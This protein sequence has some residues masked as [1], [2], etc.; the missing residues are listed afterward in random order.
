MYYFIRT[1]ADAW[2]TMCREHCLLPQ[3]IDHILELSSTAGDCPY[4][5]IDSSAIK[6]VHSDICALMAAL[7]EII[8]V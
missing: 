7:N 4:D 8:K 6:Y 1:T 5:L 3:I 2:H